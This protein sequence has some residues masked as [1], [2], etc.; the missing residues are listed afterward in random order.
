M[1]KPREDIGTNDN[2]EEEEEEE[3]EEFVQNRTRAR[4]DS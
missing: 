1:P 3:E 4:K 2:I